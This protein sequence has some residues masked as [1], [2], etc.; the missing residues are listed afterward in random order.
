MALQEIFP[1]CF[2]LGFFLLFVCFLGFFNA[3]RRVYVKCP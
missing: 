3:E 2:T 1:K